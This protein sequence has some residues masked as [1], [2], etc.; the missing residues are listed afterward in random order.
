MAEEPLDPGAEPAPPAGARGVAGLDRR[1]AGRRRRR[2]RRQGGGRSSSTPRRHADLDRRQVRPLRFAVRGP[3][4]VRGGRRRARLDVA[5]A[6]D[7]PRR[8]RGRSGRRPRLR[9][10][11]GARRRLRARGPAALL[12]GLLGRLRLGAG[13]LIRLG[14]LVGVGPLERLGRHL[15]RGE[16]IVEV[17]ELATDRLGVR[18]RRPEAPPRAP[19][20]WARAPIAPMGP[21]S[22]PPVSSR[23]IRSC[24]AKASHRAAM[25]WR[26]SA[27]WESRIPSASSTSVRL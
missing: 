13:G 14:D 6:G 4:R 12:G 7:D 21:G 16:D 26:S 25:S 2:D 3:A 17:R 20:R 1:Q 10:R 27:S 23:I 19:R 15:D 5:A 22:A 11:A 18:R 8:R 9:R 24:W